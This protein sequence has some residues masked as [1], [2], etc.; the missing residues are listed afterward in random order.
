MESIIK[1]LAGKSTDEYVRYL[2]LVLDVEKR[3]LLSPQEVSILEFMKE[4]L[5]NSGTVPNIVTG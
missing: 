5:F 3:P 4:S 2:D 1:T